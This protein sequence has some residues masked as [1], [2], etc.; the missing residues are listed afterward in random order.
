MFGICKQL[1]FISC[2]KLL[3]SEEVLH[4]NIPLFVSNKCF[5]AIVDSEN[6]WIPEG[7]RQMT[8]RI[9]QNQNIQRVVNEFINVLSDMGFQRPDIEEAVEDIINLGTCLRDIHVKY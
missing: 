7:E 3:S 5:Q 8:E 2:Y 9:T 4:F 6:G 1:Q